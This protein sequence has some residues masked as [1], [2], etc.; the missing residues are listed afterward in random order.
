MV[1]CINRAEYY[2]NIGGYSKS[3]K[4]V[5]NT[6]QTKK[7]QKRAAIKEKVNELIK[8]TGLNEYV[9]QIQANLDANKKIAQ[10]NSLLDIPYIK[11]TVDKSLAKNVYVKYIDLLNDLKKAVINDPQ[12]PEHMRDIFGDKKLVDYIKSK[13]PEIKDGKKNYEMLGVRED[14]NSEAKDPNTQS[15]FSFTSKDDKDK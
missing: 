9:N 7:D 10:I 11:D 13:F 14:P 4:D 8:R 2:E 3:T 12:I 5:C 1:G 6:L 15:Y